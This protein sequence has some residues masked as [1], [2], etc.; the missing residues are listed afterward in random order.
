MECKCQHF[1]GLESHRIFS[2]SWK[3]ESRGKWTKWFN[4]GCHIFD[5]C[6]CFWSFWPLYTLESVSLSSSTGSLSSLCH[7]WHAI[8]WKSDSPM[9]FQQTRSSRPAAK[10]KT[11]S[12]HHPT[13]GALEA[14]HH[15]DPSDPPG[16]GNIGDWCS[17]AGWGQI[18]LAAN[19]NGGMLR[20]IASRHDDD[21]DDELY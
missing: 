3:L 1:L 11:V 21:D 16:H 12:G 20:L 7:S 10:L 9:M 17:R 13:G 18:I 14:S 6:T 19:R 15:M 2:G 5:P 8:F 4:D